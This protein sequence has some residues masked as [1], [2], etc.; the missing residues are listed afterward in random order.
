VPLGAE[1]G[2][3]IDRHEDQGLGAAVMRVLRERGGLGFASGIPAVEF[4]EGVDRENGDAGLL[5]QR[6]HRRRGGS[7]DDRFA[8]DVV[9]DFDGGDAGVTRQLEERPQIKLRSDH[10]VEGKAQGHV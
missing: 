6:L 10:V 3:V 8:G 2:T 9:A 4:L 7:V 5:G 1:P